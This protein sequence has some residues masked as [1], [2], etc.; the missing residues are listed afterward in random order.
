MDLRQ[1]YN[2]VQIIERDEWKAAYTTTEG[3]FKLTVMFFRLMNLPA[4]FQTIMNKILQD[5][6][7]TGKVASFIDD[8][9]IGTEEEEKYD[10]LVEEV[11]R[12]LVENNLYIK[13][14]KCK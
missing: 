7:N 4:T 5:L 13:S 11:V 6:I 10:E 1:G 8:V 3:L 9:I 12:R 2:N 14:E